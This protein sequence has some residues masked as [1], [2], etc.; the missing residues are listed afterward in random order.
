NLGF[1]AGRKKICLFDLT[2]VFR[3]GTPRRLRLRTNLEIYW[4]ELEWA[5]GVQDVSP[6]ITR[7]NAASADLHYR[8]YSVFDQPNESSPEVPN[9]NQFAGS[10]QRWRDLIGYYTRFGD[11]RELLA[12]VD[13][14]YVIM[15]AGD[16]IALRIGAAPPPA[17]RPVAHSSP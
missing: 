7:L 6:N 9:Y 10:K 5:R 12:G 14:R 2:N 3:P 17:A 8:G 13:D 16:E 4:D 1:P 11:V 15:N